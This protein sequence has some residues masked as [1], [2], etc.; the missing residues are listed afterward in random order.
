V[1]SPLPI[2]EALPAL[3]A[4]LASRAVAVLEAPPGA[5]KTTRVPIA[6]LDAAWLH[7]ARIVMLEP[8]RLA[9]RAAAQY[10]ARTL[11]ERVGETVG[12][13]VRGE[14]RVSAATRIEVVTEGVLTRLLAHDPTLDGI[15]A[16]LFDEFH[17]RSL[18]ADLGLALALQTQALLRPELRLLVM[19]ATLDGDA[20]ARLLADDAGD[21]PV[22]R[23]HGRMF[24]V[25]TEYR[26]PRAQERLEAHVSRVVREAVAAHEGD[27]L[28][29][30][31]GAREIRRTGELLGALTDPR[32]TPVQVHELFGML[33]LGAQ[34]A[35]IA[36]APAGTRKVVLSTAIAETSLTIE[37]VR[38]VVDAG[39]A[40]V[41]RFDARMGL[42][43][44]DTVR[45]SRAGADQRRGRAGRV[46]PGTC[47]RLWDAHEDAMLVPRTRPEILD[48][49]LAP[50]ALELADAGIA[51]AAGSTCPPRADSR[52]RARCS[53]GS[54]R[55][56]PRG[57][58]CRTAARC[59]RCRCIRGSPTC[60]CSPSATD[61]A[62]WA[63]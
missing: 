60:C 8:R 56:T 24:T 13:R 61:W 63:P 41:P 32:G 36:P 34:D 50:L 57:A 62:R 11:G 3:H 10:M 38:V 42:T 31:P 40:R 16:V 25:H 44:L 9:A 1:S 5:G 23:S 54:A 21:A 55:S 14:T 43:K 26:A 53:A 49:D 18:N 33:A 6:L 48:A 4:A 20:V 35:A 29:F 15:G 22:V 52:R 2:D 58:S 46:A 47:Y 12:Y 37:G 51:D 59:S 30:L 28:V 19:S 45:V 39:R 17:E 7:G 27:V